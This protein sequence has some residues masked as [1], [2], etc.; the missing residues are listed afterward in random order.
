MK[1]LMSGISATVL[2]SADII[3]RLVTRCDIEMS[4][5]MNASD[6][7]IKITS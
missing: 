1:I 7:E 5:Q 6:V 2:R 3:P 4:A